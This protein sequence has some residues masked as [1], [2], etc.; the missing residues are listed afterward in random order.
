MHLETGLESTMQSR[1]GFGSRKPQD[2]GLVS[3]WGGKR[4]R[5]E[6]THDPGLNV[7]ICEG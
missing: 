2:N 4:E 6:D 3:H 5:N 1:D 7:T